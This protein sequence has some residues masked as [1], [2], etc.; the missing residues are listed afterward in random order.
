MAYNMGCI[1]KDTFKMKVNFNPTYDYKN[2]GT[3][4]HTEK[5]G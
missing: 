3:L 1:Y 5:S 4:V 2:E